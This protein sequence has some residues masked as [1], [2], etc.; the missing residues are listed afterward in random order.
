ME[1]NF[2]YFQY[3]RDHNYPIYLRIQLNQFDPNLPNL[4]SKM[5]FVPLSED[6]A[7]GVGQVLEE[8]SKARI[9]TIKIASNKVAR[10]VDYAVESDRFGPESIM[11]KEGYRLYRYKNMGLMVYSF[12]TQNWELGAHVNFGSEDK[13]LTSRTILNR[14]LAWS[15]YSFGV[16]GI[17]GVPV[18]EGIVVL[19][20]RES[21][22]EAVYIDLK[23]YK[24]LSEDGVSF[25][26]SRFKILRLDSTLSDRNIVM[27][28]GQLSSFLATQ[29][30]FMDYS[31]LNIPIRQLIKTL[32][33]LAEG[34]VHPRDLF[35]P[36][37]DLNP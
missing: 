17:W 35:R 27:N 26:P 6:E 12:V 21:E 1:E 13:T 2:T 30:T 25:F 3:H 19:G 5:H 4:L 34:V 14:Y 9:L 24:V 11:P 23:N 15:L 37:T 31:G 22:G 33:G 29:S 32:S 10:H 8:Q 16:V 28:Q 20:Q 18:D 36:R 7:K